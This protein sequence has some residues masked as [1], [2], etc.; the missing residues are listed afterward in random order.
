[1]KKIVAILLTLSLMGTSAVFA[2]DAPT[3]SKLSAFQNV[4]TTAVSEEDMNKVS[5]GLLLFI[6]HV[7]VLGLIT[8][9]KVFLAL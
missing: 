7:N 6:K 4:K 3:H 8:I 9:K 5:G 1:M 2:A